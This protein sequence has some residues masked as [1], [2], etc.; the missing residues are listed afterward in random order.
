MRTISGKLFYCFTSILIVFQTEAISQVTMVN[1]VVELNAPGISDQDDM[2]VWINP[3]DSSLS[4]II[5]SDKSADKLFI[6]D[7]EGEVLQTIDVSGHQPGN[8]DTRYNFLLAGELSDIVGC[9][10]RSGSELV[11]YKADRTTRQLSFAGSFASGSNYGFCLYQSPFTQ[12]FYAFSSSESGDIRQ[13]E[14]TDNNNDGVIEGT[15]VRQMSNGSGATEGMVADDQ[16]GI[17][18]A[19]DESEGIYQYNAEPNGSIIGELI[20]ATGSNG[21]TADVEGITIF[22]EREGEAYLIASSQGSN[23]FKIYEGQPPYNFIKTIVVSGVGNTDGIDAI[24]LNL[25]SLFPEGIFLVHDGTG[26]P[27]VIRG[28]RLEDLAINFVPVNFQLSV[29]VQDGWNM[30]SIPGLHPIDQNVLTWWSDKDPSADVFSYNGVYKVVNTTMLGEGYWMKH[31]GNLTYNTGEEWPEEGIQ[32][33]LND[34]ITAIAGWNLIGVFEDTVSTAGL[35]TTPPGLITGQIFE[36]SGGYKAATHLI[37]GY[38]YWVKL[39][40]SGLINLPNSDNN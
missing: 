12:K 33:V 1:P 17:L 11:F 24:N 37:P 39:T 35:T 13:Y 32:K 38:G 22:Y 10:R 31:V 20:A 5:T 8:I 26:S 2:C 3:N 6:Y 14:I 4:T 28:C 34:P 40:G 36:Y 30:V 16:T 7:L 9:N 25:G 27:F 19:A 21:L 29:T 15:L 18:Y 23:N